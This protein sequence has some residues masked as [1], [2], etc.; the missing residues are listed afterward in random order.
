MQMYSS[1]GA[2]GG[3]VVNV[4]SASLGVSFEYMEMRP[5]E[6]TRH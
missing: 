4:S 6:V 1:R 2:G 3:E 5:R